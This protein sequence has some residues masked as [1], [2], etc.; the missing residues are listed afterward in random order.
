MTVNSESNVLRYVN[1]TVEENYVNS[2]YDLVKRSIDFV[3]E[4]G[5]WTD[6]YRYVYKNEFTHS[7]TFRLYSMDGYPVFN[8]NGITEINQV[9]GRDEINKYIRPNISLELPLTTEMKKVTRPS[10]HDAL[11][12]IQNKKN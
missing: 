12:F 2:S 11:K 6:P 7:V 1:P 8:G 3:N 9:W 4:H 10:G 5:G